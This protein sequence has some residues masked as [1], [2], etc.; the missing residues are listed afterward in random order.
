M[1]RSALVKILVG[2]LAIAMLLTACSGN[3][4]SSAS[5]SG[6][7]SDS[8]SGSGSGDSREAVEL[9]WYTAINNKEAGEADVVAAV[10]EYVQEQL[11]TT[12][13]IHFYAMSEYNQAVSTMVSAGT[14]MDIVFTGAGNVDFN[15]YAARNAFTAIEDYIDEYLPQ[16]KEQ[17]PQGAWDGFTYDGH[18]Y[19]VPPMKDLAAR[20]GFLA[21]QTM[22]DDLGVEFPADSFD[23]AWDLIDWFYAVKEARDAKYPDRAENP[24]IS[25]A[26]NR[27]DQY[28]YYEGIVGG[29]VDAMVATNVPGLSGFE[30]YGEGETAFCPFFTDEYVEMMQQVRALVADGVAPFDSENFDPD[31]VLFNAGELLGAYPQGYIY[32]DPDM[33]APYYTTVHYPAQHSLMTT[34]YVQSGAQAIAATSEN[35]ERSLEFLELLNNDTYLATTIRFGVEGEGWTDE[36]NDGIFEDGP[37]NADTNNR[38]WYNWYGWR[39]GSIIVSKYPNSYPENFGELVQELNDNSNQDTNLGFIFDP[40]NVENEIAA[41]NNVIDQYYKTLQKG[42]TDDIDAQVDAFIADLKANGSDTIVEE[43]QRQLD[44]WRASVGKTVKE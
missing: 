21:N 11:N 32:V 27:L 20:W 10:N 7:G 25:G 39:F 12:L 40:T 30:G 6:S 31:D 2:L 29:S 19:A 4:S 44:E 42:Q 18:I 1:K 35:V 5:G 33:N 36:D 34:A 9:E 22:I 17:L 24:V 3:S 16:T 41:C 15:S 28:Y 23:T 38:N 26:P 14:Y 8:G 13:N 37:K 43:A